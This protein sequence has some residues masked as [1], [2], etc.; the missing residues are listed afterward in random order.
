MEASRAQTENVASSLGKSWRKE[1]FNP[2][3]GNSGTNPCTHSFTLSNVKSPLWTAA[4]ILEIRPIGPQKQLMSDGV[5]THA[6]VPTKIDEISRLQQYFEGAEKNSD[7]VRRW[8]FDCKT[9][10]QRKSCRWR[11]HGW[12][13]SFDGVSCK[14]EKQ[15]NLFYS[16]WGFDLGCRN[17][18]NTYTYNATIKIRSFHKVQMKFFRG[19]LNR[20]NCPG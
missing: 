12:A 16:T 1:R 13:P 10:Q 19:E 17:V 18:C 2:S 7:P 4:M 5:R 11:S 9:K 15:S 3:P 8:R 6:H 14:T 20:I